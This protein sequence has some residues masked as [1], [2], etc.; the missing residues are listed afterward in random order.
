MAGHLSYEDSKKAVWKGL[1]L[2]AAVTLA[3]VFLSLMKAAEWAEDIQWV[4]VL[5]S[6]L[7]I[8]L[9]VYKAYFIIYE[10]MHMG[11]EVKGLAMSVLLPMF[12]LVWALIAFFSEGSYWK[13]N[14][15]EIEDRNQL[16]ATPGVGAVI[17]DEDFVV[18]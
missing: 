12:L 13:D 9:S 8:I 15:A 1:G 3:E 6:L 4:F 7:I 18:G 17:T 14:R 11:Y 5:A 16:E 2:L 10:F